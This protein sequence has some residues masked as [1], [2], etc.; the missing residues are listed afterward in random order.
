MIYLKRLIF[1]IIFLFVFVGYAAQNT[2]NSDPRAVNDKQQLIFQVMENKFIL[3]KADIEK[4][5]LQPQKDGQIRSI[6]IQL[7]DVASKRFYAFTGK[8]IGQRMQIV[9]NGTILS[10]TVIMSALPGNMVLSFDVDS[11]VVQEMVSSL[12]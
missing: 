12:G 6:E 3:N 11:S 5:Q 1:T 2:M 9:W 7:T 10:D 8:N 4:I